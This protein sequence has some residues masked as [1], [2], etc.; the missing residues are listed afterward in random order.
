M[1]AALKFVHISALVVW[2]AGLV[3]LPILLHF[4]GRSD[5][6]R[7]QTGFERLRHLTHYSYIGVLS[8]AAVIAIAAGTGLIFLMELVDIWLLAKLV[9]VAGMALIHAW[10]G[11]V[12]SEIGHGG[13]HYRLPPTLLVLWLL[14]P[15]MGVVL[16]LVLA[17]PDLTPLIEQL[18]AFMRIPQ[19]RELPEGV[20]PI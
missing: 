20:V 4:Y 17:K 6:H 18:P 12:T 10:L 11:H 14:F 16:F 13:G 1:I 19:G 7:T 3:A 8:P 5:T 2:C 15:L 9:A